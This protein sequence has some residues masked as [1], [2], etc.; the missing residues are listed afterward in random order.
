MEFGALIRKMID[1][2]IAGD[3]DTVASCFTPDGVYHD[4]F[5]GAFEGRDR[6]AEMIR[7][8]FHRDGCNFRWDTH[9]PVSD[10]TTGYVRYVFSY[11]S[12]LEAAKGK[13]TM[14]EGVAVVSLENGLMKTY[15]EV[16]NSAPGL[17]RIGFEPERLA[18]FVKKQGAELAAR[19]ESEGHL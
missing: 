6:I 19:D 7:D 9:N 10:G 11:E 2:V 4:V 16:A 3:G 8:Y 14:F 12:K 18:R 17:Q 1:G 5:Y 15:T 13:R